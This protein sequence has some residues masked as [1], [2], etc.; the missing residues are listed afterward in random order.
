MSK[1]KDKFIKQ[2]F[3]F[4][5]T[6]FPCTWEALKEKHPNIQ[7]HASLLFTEN[8]LSFN[9][10]DIAQLDENQHIELCF[11]DSLFFNSGLPK[12][13]VKSMLSANLKK[14][15]CYYLS[16]LSWDFEKGKWIEIMDV[17]EE[18]Y[19][20][21]LQYQSDA[22][23]DII[24]ESLNKFQLEDLNEKISQAIEKAV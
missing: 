22:D 19:D 18:K 9:P 1:P 5:L 8:Y 2:N 20:K 17:I 3:T 4:Q 24:I 12:E 23:M 10:N 14:P 15:F 6:L 21:F 7:F 13:Y 11:L 16:A